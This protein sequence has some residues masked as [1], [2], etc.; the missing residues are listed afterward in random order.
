ML[1]QGQLTYSLYHIC[2]YCAVQGAK[3]LSIQPGK[4][5]KTM[6]VG[7]SL[8]DVLK[9]VEKEAVAKK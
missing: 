2:G 7:K 5:G 8:Q 3:A 1:P 9:E 4:Y 6:Y